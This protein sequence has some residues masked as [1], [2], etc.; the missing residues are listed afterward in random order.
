MKKQTLKIQC[1]DLFGKL[2]IIEREYDEPATWQEAIKIDGESK[3][4]GIFL[5]KRKTNFMDTERR[6][7]QDAMNKLFKSAMN[8]PEKLAKIEAILASV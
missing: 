1:K 8:D 2:K 4:F 7:E 3:A 5:N 6:Q